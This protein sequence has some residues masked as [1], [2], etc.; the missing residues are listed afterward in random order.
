MS[1][2][3]VKG[4]TYTIESFLGP[5]TWKSGTDPSLE[6]EKALLDNYEPGSQSN[7][8]DLYYTIIYLAPGD[9]HR[10]HS[11]TDWTINYRRHFPGKL[12]SVRPTFASWFP[13]LFA[14]NERVAYIG[15]W[16]HGFF[17]MAP[18]G[19]VNVGS[20]NIYFDKVSLPLSYLSHV[21]YGCFTN[22]VL[23]RN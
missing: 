20:M 22:L 3:Q 21:V 18:V 13:N 19:A 10:F 17:A 4:I 14:V 8:T 9:Y 2:S 23:H 5:I 12:Y 11:P 7:P 16:K 15:K 6:Y 1:V